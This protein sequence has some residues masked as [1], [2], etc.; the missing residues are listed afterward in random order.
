M[1]DAHSYRSSH[2]EAERVIKKLL[3]KAETRAAVLEKLASSI[4]KANRLN[5]EGWELSLAQSEN[6]ARLNVG[7]M[8]VFEIKAASIGLAL[9][10][11]SGPPESPESERVHEFKMVPGVALWRFPH[12]EVV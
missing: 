7:G 6:Y 9:D 1:S 5:P 3:P 12:N 11:E 8:T 2:D 10:E 4:S